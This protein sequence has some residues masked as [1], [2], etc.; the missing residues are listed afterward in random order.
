MLLQE[1]KKKAVGLENKNF[2]PSKNAFE[3]FTQ[4]SYKYSTKEP[5]QNSHE[6]LSSYIY[7]NVK[8]NLFLQLLCLIF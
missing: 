5:V 8:E 7:A 1:M 3:N 4:R 2:L 6:T